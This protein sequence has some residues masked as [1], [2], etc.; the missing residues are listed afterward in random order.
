MLIDILIQADYRKWQD[1]PKY[2]EA[3]INS[4]QNF[5]RIAKCDLTM[6]K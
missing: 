4:D 6:S 2:C 3:L 5:D 1:T